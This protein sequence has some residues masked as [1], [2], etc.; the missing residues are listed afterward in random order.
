MTSLTP[1]QQ[2]VQPDAT[3]TKPLPASPTGRS[4]GQAEP[5]TGEFVD[6]FLDWVEHQDAEQAAG[7]R[8][9]VPLLAVSPEASSLL[10]WLP[11]APPRH[12]GRVGSPQ[13]QWR[14]WVIDGI[15]SI[16][17]G[18]AAVMS[19]KI[20]EE[21]PLTPDP[22]DT[23]TE[24]DTIPLWTLRTP[25]W[26]RVPYARDWRAWQE[27]LNVPALA[28][29]LI[30]FEALAGPSLS[31]RSDDSMLERLSRDIP[32]LVRQL[33]P[34]SAVGMLA[35]ARVFAKDGM[36]LEDA[37]VAASALE[38]DPATFIRVKHAWSGTPRR[39]NESECRRT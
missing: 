7:E 27:L 28:E 37:V 33:P 38:V 9:R 26:T 12:T 6:V 29:S 1:G 13:R 24:S 23:L 36:T 34:A 19:Y 30:L 25:F 20:V 8:A 39:S 17:D 22:A 31:Q 16:S 11:A 10:T 15:S 4:N 2:E 32:L 35:T 14:N 18:W 5:V 21:G 3:L